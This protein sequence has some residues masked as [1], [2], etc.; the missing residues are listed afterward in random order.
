MEASRKDWVRAVM[1]PGMLYGA[2][3]GVA[4]GGLVMWV[5]PEAFRRWQDHVLFPVLSAAFGPMLAWGLTVLAGFVRWLL[6][7]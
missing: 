5:F 4:L 7:R 6:N 2:V 3:G 1:M